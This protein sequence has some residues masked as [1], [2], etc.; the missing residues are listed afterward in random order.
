MNWRKLGR[1]RRELRE[2]LISY[3]RRPLSYLFL[4]LSS[5]FQ[6]F[7]SVSSQFLFNTNLYLRTLVLLIRSSK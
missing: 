4:G 7:L 5:S 1:G 2:M 3:D 6:L